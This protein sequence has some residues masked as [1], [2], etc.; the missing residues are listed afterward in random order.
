MVG[1][2]KCVA[3]FS[4]F[5][6]SILDFS[7]I[8]GGVREKVNSAFDRARRVLSWFLLLRLWSPLWANPTGKYANPDPEYPTCLQSTMFD[9]SALMSPRVFF[10]KT[11]FSP[12]DLCPKFAYPGPR[13][14]GLVLKRKPRRGIIDL[15]KLLKLLRKRPFLHHIVS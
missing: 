13:I 2:T 6:D 9:L 15:C 1:F 12:A 10:Q 4:L 7:G 3:F 5:F 11:I 14:F 8:C